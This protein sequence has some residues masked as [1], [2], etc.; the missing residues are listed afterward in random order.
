MELTYYGHSCFLAVSGSVRVVVDPFISPN[1]LAEDVS[2]SN[3]RPT[4]I[5]VT[6]G[7]EDHIA[8]VE[9]LMVASGAELIAPYE[10][11]NWFGEKGMTPIRPVNPG[12]ELHL[13]SQGDSMRVRVV[14]AVHSS[15][16]PDGS[17]GGVACGFVLEGGGQRAYH[18]GDTDLSLEMELIGRHWTPDVALLPIGGTFTMGYKD[19]PVA[20]D[21]LRCKRVVGM[22]Y[23]TFPPIEIDEESALRTAKE[24]GGE[25]H[26][27]PVGAV[28]QIAE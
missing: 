7:H 4:H 13:G 8:D 24:A 17:P 9:A 2:L 18:A 19:V 28:L 15:T 3:V 10:V 6:H 25:L 22:H 5:L 1:P 16:L 12:A 23:N 27:M 14:G 26:L 20:M 11:A 21:M